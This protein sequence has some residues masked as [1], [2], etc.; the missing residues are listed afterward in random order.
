MKP[1]TTLAPALLAILLA[2][3][4]EDKKPVDDTLPVDLVNTFIGSGGHYWE[5][6]SVFP[7]ASRPF[8]M[9]KPGP[10]TCPSF[11][12]CF[13]FHH[14]GGYH[15]EDDLIHG[16]SQVH[17]SGTG[18]ADYGALLFMPTVGFDAEKTTESKYLSPFSKENEQASPGA[19]SVRLDDYDIQVDLTASERCAYHR[20]TYP[21]GTADAYV[22]VDLSHAI[23]T[24]SVSQARLDVDAGAREI[25][26]WLQYHGSLTG[27]AGGFRL[28][29]SAVFNRP[30][31]GWT[32]WRD[33]ELLED[34]TSA[35]GV[36][37]GVAVAVDTAD[38]VEVQIGL[39]YVDVEGAR[40]NRQA[41]LS[42]T[43]FESVRAEARQAWVEKLDRITIQGGTRDERVIFYSALYHAMLHP[44]LFT[45]TDGR[46][47]GFDKQAHTASGFLY[48]TD[49]SMWDTYRNV[50]SLFDLIVPDRQRDMVVS[51]LKMYEEGGSL[52]KWPAATGYTGC[53]LGTP[54][55]IIIS[56]TY[57]KGI[58]DFDVETAFSAMKEHATGPVENAGRSGIEYYMT[59]G[60]VPA[61]H[62]GGSVS[63]TQ[64]FCIADA[65]IA[66][67]AE[68]L[69]K[70]QDAA[71][72]L[73]RSKNYKNH[74]DP[75][76]QF[77]RGK[78]E[79]GSWVESDE[80]FD[81][82]DWNAEYYTEGDA[83]QYLWLAPHD[84]QGLVGLFG[85]ADAMGDKL[86]TFFATPEPDTGGLPPEWIPPRYYW[87]GNEPDLH[88]AYLF[89][90]VGRPDRAQNWVRHILATRYHPQAAGIPGN[91]DLGTMSSWYVFS[92]SGFY[93]IAG[94][95]RYYVG[96]PL[97]SE[98]TFQLG[99]GKTLVIKAKNADSENKYIQSA[100]LNGRPLDVPWFDHADIKDGGVLELKMGSQPSDWGQ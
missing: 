42:E 48:Y 17:I 19:Y 27:R 100:K 2:G 26:G 89:N 57:Q 97:F 63:H 35:E 75:A 83:W 70:T 18:G 39:S 90:E 20:Y 45:D 25:S 33:G 49:F 87:H 51:L 55:D 73:A 76:T 34:E 91:D 86:E 30:L 41:E 21:P 61:D 81:P 15:Y 56:E 93:P 94:L 85:S 77:M 36:D 58:T 6:G 22:I 24:C 80:E 59:I 65:A 11:D 23:A 28:Y 99:E 82:L 16:F 68:L 74:W 79:D 95:T 52:P 12:P 71:D 7:G 47:T 14:F 53:M 98:I 60:Y 4:G 43:D 13:E 29:F 40:K 72:F 5:F 96:S 37:L 32:V 10:D 62:V 8:G 46:Y 64:E 44:T 38:P 88:A 54:A 66:A 31:S 1:T 3:C 84:P 92:S 67:L 9:A 50:H 78:N 69:S